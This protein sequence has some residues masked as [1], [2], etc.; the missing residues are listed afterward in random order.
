[1]PRG[2]WVHVVGVYNG[3]DIYLFQNANLVGVAQAQFD[4]GT[5]AG[6]FTLSNPAEPLSGMLD[7]VSLYN[8]PLTP[9][10]IRL[11]YYMGGADGKCK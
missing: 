2:E 4:L 10:E 7:E 3:D 1:M 9:G 11:L 5:T 6:A 8:R